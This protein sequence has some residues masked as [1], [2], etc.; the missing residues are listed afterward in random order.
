MLKQKNIRFT[1]TFRAKKIVLSF[2]DKCGK[3]FAVITSIE[4]DV[5]FS[6]KSFFRRAENETIINATGDSI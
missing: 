4:I 2:V 5:F 1:M 6:S 3:S